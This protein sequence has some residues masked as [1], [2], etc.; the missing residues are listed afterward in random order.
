M[1]YLLPFFLIISCSLRGQISSTVEI[2][3]DN[4]ISQYKNLFINRENQK[5]TEFAS[6]KL[7]EYFGSKEEL[8]YIL[9][10]V[11]R[12]LDSYNVKLSNVVFEKDSLIMRKENEMQRLV[13]LHVDYENDKVKLSV[14]SALVLISFDEGKTWYYSFKVEDN[15]ENNKLLGL[16]QDII[17]PSK[18]LNAIKK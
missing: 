8:I 13:K 14:D 4:A 6:P 5:L 9:E 15:P 1:R 16:H 2:N 10:E 18:I 3:I 12:S 17:M 11:N 7:V